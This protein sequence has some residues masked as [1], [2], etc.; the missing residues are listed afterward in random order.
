MI[1]LKDENPT[2]RTPIVTM[3][4][5]AIC[6]V[7]YFFVQQGAG[8]LL[9]G[10]P[11]DPGANLEF[12]LK[13]AAIPC[14]VVQ[15]R[16]L[17]RG[18]IV[19]T[20]TGSGNPAACQ[21]DP[22]T[23]AGFGGKSVYLAIITSMF[24]HGGLLHLAGNMLYLWVFGNNIEDTQ[25]KVPYV[26][27]YLLS[28]LAATVAHIAV[29][30]DS[31]VPVVGASGAIAGVMGAYLVLFPRVPIKT[32][33]IFFF[34]LFRDVQARWLLGIWFVSQFFINPNAGVAWMAH[35]GGFLFGIL[36]GL[37]WRARRGPQ[38][39]PNPYYAPYR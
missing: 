25:G 22:A 11:A 37:V 3:V 15:G 17:T 10:E 34:I 12:T 39:V 31:T 5:I 9:A 27:F 32:V 8:E 19:D 29:Q 16:P 18:E 26:L 28:G 1:P 7:V 35:V 30:P 4:L 23:P 36:G 2:K 38:P 21:A 6:V 33:I 20:F 13:N 24:L 14:E